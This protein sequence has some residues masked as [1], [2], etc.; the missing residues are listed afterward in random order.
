VIG[1][2]PVPV[3]DP[4]FEVAVKDDAV[5]PNAAAVYSTVAVVPVTAVAV[6]IVGTVGV[7]TEAL[8]TAIDLAIL[9]DDPVFILLLA[10]KLGTL[11]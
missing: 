4:G 5:A 7:A 10:I 1:E 2:E 11:L 3:S 9:N 6:P 8:L